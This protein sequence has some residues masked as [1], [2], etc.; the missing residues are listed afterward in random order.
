MLEDM[1]IS[2]LVNL[3][4]KEE[5]SF[6]LVSKEFEKMGFNIIAQCLTKNSPGADLH[7]QKGNMV[8]RVEIKNARIKD[9]RNSS[10]IP[11]VEE[12]RKNDDLI[13]IVFP[14]GYVLI[15]PMKQ[16]LTCVGEYGS[17]SFYGIF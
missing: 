3:D 10:E 6:K 17:R 13:A 15:E 2:Q 12:A 9:G 1:K 11:P 7:I 8:L 16:H 4:L 5:L 14:S